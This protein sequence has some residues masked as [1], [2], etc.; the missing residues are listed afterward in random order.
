MAR[1]NCVDIT[2]KNCFRQPIKMLLIDA[3][4]GGLSG[5][6]WRDLIQ[7]AVRRVW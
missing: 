6:I 2:G 7:W 5:L 4:G 1:Y 3:F